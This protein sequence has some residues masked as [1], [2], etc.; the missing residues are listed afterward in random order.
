MS[1]SGKDTIKKVIDGTS[2]KENARCVVDWFSSTIEGQQFLSDMID[3]DSYLMEDEFTGQ[4]TISSLQSEVILSKI[5]KEIRKKQFVRIS[6]RVAALVI[7]FVVLL[8]FGLYLNSQVDLFGKSPY[9]EIYIPRGESGRILFQDGSEAYL[10]ADTKIRYPQKFGL[11]KRQ[12]YVDGEA[13]FNVS[14]AKKRPFIVHA[15]NTSVKVLGTSFNVKAYNNEEKIEVVLDE[16]KI[17]FRTSGNRYSLSP[18]QLV[19]YHKTNGESVVRNLSKSTNLSLW[20]NNIIYFHDTPLTEVL[21]ML[22]R[23]YGVSFEVKD[24]KA[25]EYSYTI[26]TRQTTITDIL[27]ELQKIAPVK[28]TFQKDA[29]LVSLRRH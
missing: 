20:K 28:F 26:T 5:N 7:P 14:P 15:G 17:E 19:V 13:Y 22:E 8:G 2:S 21:R 10:N 23:R 9:A 12:V 16:G 27:S 3:R 24:R 18:G 25:L 29:I 11:T 1:L 6:F 4:K